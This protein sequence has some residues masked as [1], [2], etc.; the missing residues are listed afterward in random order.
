MV[1]KIINWI[2]NGFF[3]TLGKFLFFFLIACI[4]G[5]LIGNGTVKLTDLLGI[6]IVYAETNANYSSIRMDVE[7]C[8]VRPN[9]N[10]TAF[11]NCVWDH[12]NGLGSNYKISFGSTNGYLRKI[13]FQFFGGSNYTYPAGSYRVQFQIAQDPLD[14]LAFTDY[15]DLKIYGNSSSSSS[16]ASSGLD[17]ITSKSCTFSRVT[18]YRVAVNCAFTTSRDLKYLNV[19]FEYYDDN[20]V[21]LYNT[22][23]IQWDS[24]DQFVYST[25]S[26]GAINNQTTIIQNEF[27]NLDNTL[28]DD[29]V[30]EDTE[31]MVDFLT[32]FDFSGSAD[33]SSLVTLPIDFIANVFLNDTTADLCATFRGKNIC[34]PNGKLLWNRTYSCNMQTTLCDNSVS[35]SSFKQIFSILVGGYFAYK[36]LRGL[37][38]SVD[39][40]ADPTIDSVEMADLGGSYTP[41]HRDSFT[42]S[43]A[44]HRAT[45]GRRSQ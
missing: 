14:M 3:R 25:D 21:K 36:M 20:D 11:N 27:Q 39:E 29:D 28:T 1:K 18:T 43:T 8:S 42:R 12:T 6:D 31:D 13:Q 41:K 23:A 15:Y 7:Q 33:V 37:V 4:V 19:S 5:I 45:T 2:A 32:D 22:T 35:I 30:D 26:T 40:V 44:F 9:G 17:T 10:T 38:R 16:G 34:L 24:I